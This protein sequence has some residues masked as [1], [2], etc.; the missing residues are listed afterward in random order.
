LYERYYYDPGKDERGIDDDTAV[1]FCLPVLCGSALKNRGV[2][3]LLDAMVAL[4]P[5]PAGECFIIIFIRL[6]D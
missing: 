2:Q 3:P 6:Y 1:P 4:F 5:S